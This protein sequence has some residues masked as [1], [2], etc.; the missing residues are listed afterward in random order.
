MKIYLVGGAV[1]DKL[2]GYPYHEKD[3]V[4]V[5]A[6]PEQ[7]LA[8]GYQQV[9]KDF[10]VFLH[11]ESKEEYALARTERKIAAGY[12]GFECFASPDVTLEEDLERRDLTINAI[13]ED[14]EGV[15]TD[16][17]GGQQDL[18][19]KVL[20]HV[21]SAFAEDPLRVLRVARFSA[22]YR[23]LGFTL[24]PET[25]ELMQTISSKDELLALPAERV[26]KELQRSLDEKS[27]QQF[28]ITLQQAGALEKLMPELFPL[29]DKS[30]ANLEHAAALGKPATVI[31]ALLLFQCKKD[32]A[33]ILCQRLK[34]PNEFKD[35]AL[36]VSNFGFQCQSP[37]ESA[38]QLLK[39]VEQLDPFRRPERFELFLQCCELYFNEQHC[40]SQLRL[41]FQLCDDI[42]AALLAAEG[43]SGKA[44]GQ[45][46][47]QRRLEAIDN[48]LFQ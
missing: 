21:S 2:L 1:R 43:L 6:T 12:T 45:A 23:H 33:K 9:G 47:R 24:A 13:A 46:L 41:G 16:P 8:Q 20:R 42:N 44:I 30:I 3:W 29:E 7:L 26:W 22:R 15:L 17:Y 11:P 32:N 5:G 37:V 38:E 39:L 27:P 36:L 25:L 10:P 34:I 19:N 48:A 28:F 40:S 35:L 4:V 18:Q 31:F 14:S